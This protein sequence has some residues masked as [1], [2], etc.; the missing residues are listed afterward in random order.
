MKEKDYDMELQAWMIRILA[1]GLAGTLFFFC[2]GGFFNAISGEDLVFL[3]GS[4]LPFQAVS[5]TLAAATG[6]AFLAGLIQYGL[7]FA[8]GAGIG[9]ATLPFAEDGKELLIRSLLHFAYSAAI[10]SALLWL[11]GWNRGSFV[12]WL[13]ELGILVLLYLLIWFGRWLS[14]WFELDAIRERLGLAPPVSPLK[15]RETLPHLGF[16]ALL[17]LAVPALLLGL[18]HLFHAP[19]MDRLEVWACFLVSPL[20]ALC[21]LVPGVSLGR[22]HGICPLYPIAIGLFLLAALAV[23]YDAGPLSLP[24]AGITALFA[25]TGNLIGTLRRRRSSVRQSQ[26]ER[27]RV[28]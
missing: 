3:P 8:L 17:C 27:G 18:L 16:A 23:F 12:I 10:S 22:R 24:C 6:S 7:Y 26:A 25:L 21:S 14:W 28:G 2:L 5:S 1:G 20:A 4:S 13:A 9:V 11:S 19:A 15:V